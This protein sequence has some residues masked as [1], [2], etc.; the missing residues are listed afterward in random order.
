M[1]VTF[2][3]GQSQLDASST[4]LET[5]VRESLQFAQHAALRHIACT[6]HDNT[7]VLHGRVPSYYLK[8]LA[9]VKVTCVPGI[10]Q[11]DNH[12]EVAVS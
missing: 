11:V 1:D 3:T 8:Q 5:E 12:I 10:E 4:D 9:Q 7:V 6:V 2:V